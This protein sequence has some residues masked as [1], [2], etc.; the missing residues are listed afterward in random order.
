MSTPVT[1]REIRR[2]LDVT[3]SQLERVETRLTDTDDPVELT[4]DGEAAHEFL[5]QARETL[6]SGTMMQE[7]EVRR[8]LDLFMSERGRAFRRRSNQQA[9]SS[10]Q[11][12]AEN[13][14]RPSHRPQAEAGSSGLNNI[15][16]GIFS[17]SLEE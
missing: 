2:W 11:E 17:R 12:V 14:T 1:Q 6:E 15:G 10:Y 5:I 7:E 4:A 16:Y 8:A 9:Q 13:R 3:R